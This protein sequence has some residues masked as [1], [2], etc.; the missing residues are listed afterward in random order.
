MADHCIACQG[1]GEFS[2][3]ALEVRTLPVRD[4]GGEKKVQALGDF[5]EVSVCRSCA[6]KQLGL[7]LDPLKASRNSN[8]RFGGILLL[9]LVLV[10]LNY[11]FLGGGWMYTA[12]G[13][14][15]VICGVLGIYENVKTGRE[16]KAEL[17]SLSP[18]KALEK[19]AWSAAL[20]CLPK[21]EPSDVDLTY[22]PVTE[23][24]LARKNG[25]L[26]ILY[27]LVP[28]IALEAHKKIHEK[29]A[30]HQS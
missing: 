2:F 3:R 26:M 27:H 29:A 1:P 10:V 12:L 7:E 25:D 16:K 18:E 4:L 24:T 6:E 20:A 19:A 11:L 9:G 17:T 15:A 14:A 23:E 21:K 28:A 22:I 8:L 30:S 13:I 5:I